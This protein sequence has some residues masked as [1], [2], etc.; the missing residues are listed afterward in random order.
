MLF[1]NEK[2]LEEENEMLKKKY[3]SKSLKKFFIGT[4]F[5]A[6][7]VA[8][9][10]KLLKTKPAKETKKELHK[11]NKKFIKSLDKT[12]DDLKE[13]AENVA[14]EIEKSLPDSK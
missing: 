3:H 9:A 13:T 4:G 7:I 12:V 1:K 5:G 10:S 2:K 6:L 14:E 8:V 11:F